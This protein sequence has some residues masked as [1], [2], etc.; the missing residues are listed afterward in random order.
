LKFEEPSPAHRKKFL[1]FLDFHQPQYHKFQKAQNGAE[2][3]VLSY[4]FSLKKRKAISLKYHIRGRNPVYRRKPEFSK[5]ILEIQ[6]N[7]PCPAK[8]K[9]PLFSDSHQRKPRL[10]SR[11]QNGAKVTVTRFPPQKKTKKQ[12]R[13][14]LKGRNPL[15]PTLT[16]VY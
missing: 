9:F 7:Q 12:A 8:K 10:F 15:L 5:K 13:K 14:K 6:G 1:L 3:T 16:R 2:T 4:F 11:A